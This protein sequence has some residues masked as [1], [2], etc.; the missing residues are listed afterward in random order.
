[1]KAFAARATASSN[2]GCGG[3]IG[4]TFW[5]SP[6]SSTRSFTVTTIGRSCAGAS[7]G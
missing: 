4:S 1:M 3:V 6:W 7:S 5:T 2:G